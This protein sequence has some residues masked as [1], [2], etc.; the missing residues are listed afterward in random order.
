MD[1]SN[2]PFQQNIPQKIGWCKG[3]YYPNLPTLEP[4]DIVLQFTHARH[5]NTNQCVDHGLCHQFGD[6]SSI[7]HNELRSFPQTTRNHLTIVQT[8]CPRCNQPLTNN[9]FA[10]QQ[11]QPLSPIVVEGNV[12]VQNGNFYNIMKSIS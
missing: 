4:H 11:R 5:K 3:L 12:N 9:N 8:H 7:P 6:Q 1:L 10:R 2:E